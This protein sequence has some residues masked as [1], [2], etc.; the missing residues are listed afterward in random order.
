M[1]RQFGKWEM[2]ESLSE[3]GQAWVYLVKETNGSSEERY[4]L[5][6][7]KNPNRLDR[8]K[9]EIESLQELDHP[10][11]AKL[12]DFDLID[13]NPCFVQEYYPAGD[14]EQYVKNHTPL[15]HDE[16]LNLIIEI[17]TSL[18][19]AHDMG[20]FIETSNLRIYS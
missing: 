5:K 3:G 11:I 1:G 14:I 10:G 12:I 13:K 6:R 17:A 2:I 18:E 15:E 7:L 9:G 20:K 4:V 16:V 19:Y 8:F